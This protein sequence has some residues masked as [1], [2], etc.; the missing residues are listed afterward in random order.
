MDSKSFGANLHDLVKA[1]EETSSLRLAE[2]GV[3]ISQQLKEFRERQGLSQSDLA[4]LL[5]TG[6][7]RVSQ[8]EDPGYAKLSLSSLAKAAVCLDCELVVELRAKGLAKDSPA[9]A[10]LSQAVLNML[11]LN[12]TRLS[13]VIKEKPLVI[14]EDPA[15]YD[16]I[17]VAK[18]KDNVM[19]PGEGLRKWVL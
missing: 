10:G 4:K 3:Q 2:I 16:V 5:G 1:I 9:G 13:E 8:M 6:Q 19:Y 15:A 17:D 7:S 14:M 12:S 18:Q 11:D